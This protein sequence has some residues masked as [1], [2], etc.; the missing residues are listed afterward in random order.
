MSR[1][2][3][4]V[5]DLRVKAGGFLL[6]DINFE[7]M[8]DEYLVILG[9]TGSGKTVLLES[10]AGLRDIA[11][12]RVC[13]NGKD[14]THEPPENRYLG[15]AYQDGLLY[16]FL[17]VRENVLFG[18]RA[19]G[20]A[21]DPGVIRR[22]EQL[23]ESMGI[24][25]LLDRSPKNLSGGE[26][27][28]V[29]LA[30]AILTRPEV[31]L[32]DEPLSALDPQ[33]R[34]AMQLLLKEIHSAEGLGI[35]HVTHDFSETLQLGTRVIIMNNGR[36]EQVGHPKEV[37]FYPATE[38]SAKFI[39]M[40]NIIRGIIRKDNQGQLWFVL[41]NGDLNFGPLSE[42]SFGTGQ[43]PQT[44][45]PAILLV[46]AG[47]IRL[48]HGDPPVTAVNCW[49]AVIR[50]VFFDRT[51]VDVYCDGK[52]LWR[53]SLSFF[54]WENLGL[55]EGDRVRLSVRPQDIH[56]ISGEG[57]CDAEAMPSKGFKKYVF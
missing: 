49:E 26:R 29:S 57:H 53:T 21:G 28:R 1:V 46:R 24:S 48:E 27:Q 22:M 5:A 2:L 23:V 50:N 39:G 17:S 14:I 37:F 55:G 13:L 9:P 56:L 4:E 19:R 38:F 42:G 34:H 16:N 33:T 30:R 54:E 12:G 32:L 41:E 43:L 25:H 3:L 7:M 15:F 8:G 52:G 31:L 20:M 10:L 35:I 40:E 45:E 47:N 44:D 51:H 36:M 11:G 18:A 6:R